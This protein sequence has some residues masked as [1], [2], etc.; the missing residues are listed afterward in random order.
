MSAHNFKGR[1]LGDGSEAWTMK[2]FRKDDGKTRRLM[3]AGFL[4]A[5][6]TQGAVSVA[7]LKEVQ[8]PMYS[9]LSYASNGEPCICPRM[10]F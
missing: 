7:G 4:P 5:V 6:C 3:C 2:I 9:A 10:P 1:C 8:L